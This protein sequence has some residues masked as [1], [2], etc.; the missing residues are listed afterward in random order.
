[1]TKEKPETAPAQAAEQP[2]EEVVEPLP[3]LKNLFI[4][5]P[6]Q[7]NGTAV[8]DEMLDR[9]PL[10]HIRVE[11]PV[12]SIR[13]AL[14]E[15]CGYSHLTNY[16]FEL[17]EAPAKSSSEKSGDNLPI[18][19]PYTG[20]SA[21]VAVPSTLKSLEDAYEE[22]TKNNESVVLDDYGDLSPLLENGLK[23]GS[24]FRIVL[25]RY[26]VAQ[27]RDHV[28]RLRSLLDGNAPSATTL[29]DSAD[30]VT[31]EETV[32]DDQTQTESGES[33]ENN[34]QKTKGNQNDAEKKKANLPAYPSGKSIVV[35]SRALKDFYYLVCG[36]DPSL[37][38]DEPTKLNSAK[39][40]NGSKKKKDNKVKVNGQNDEKEKEES[41]IEEKV[42]GMITQ[43]NQLEEKTRVK[44]SMRL[45]GFH[46]PP[47]SRRLMGDLAYLE[48]VPP[49]ESEPIFITAI[50]AGF[51]VNRSKSSGR[52]QVKFDPSP[53]AEPCFSHELLDCLLQASKS[54]L[55]A[56]TNAI[57]CSKTRN[58]LMLKLNADGHFASLFR[59]AIRGDF[60]GYQ[61][62]STGS[63][64][65][66]ID[67]LVQTPSWLVSIPRAEVEADEAWNRNVM[68]DYNQ[69][70]TED[71]LGNSFGV[72]VRNGT[73]RDWNEELQAAR[74]MSDVS[75]PERIERA[76]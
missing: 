65:D 15:V 10:P 3:V 58:S 48:V 21:V 32:E 53:A 76:R 69:A 24:A 73:A 4:L 33:K 70:R 56:W 40:E 47:R 72:D 26:D 45:S 36:E 41:K 74:E 75:M 8:R 19:S 22:G 7:K 18:I 57:A 9:V 11:E 34:N 67:A 54:F 1:M 31:E 2:A 42:R 28:N 25:E 55:D 23:D 12:A 43:L 13:A 62:A 39:Q 50:P 59:V 16:R 17:E 52:G 63:A 49:G 44:C 27:I 14:G 46:P 35:D 61:N 29:T 64:A 37:Y 51:Y 66:G 6:L 38:L 5:P 60:K 20:R 30:A 71:D 68:H